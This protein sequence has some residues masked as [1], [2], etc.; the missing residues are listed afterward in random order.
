MIQEENLVS[1]EMALYEKI[2]RL[3]GIRLSSHLTSPHVLPIISW[4]IPKNSIVHYRPVRKD[5]FGPNATNYLFKGWDRSRKV[6]VYHVPKLTSLI[7]DPRIKPFQTLLAIRA[8]RKINPTLKWIREEKYIQ[9]MYKDPNALLCFNYG[10]ADKTVHYRTLPLSPLYEW[11]NQ[12][13]TMWDEVAKHALL[14]DRQQFIEFEVPMNL[15]L[16]SRLETASKEF[17]RMYLEDFNKPELFDLL[18]LWKWMNPETRKQSHISIVKEQHLQKVNLLFTI[19]SHVCLLN[20]GK[21]NTWIM[22]QD[23]EDIDQ[24]DENEDGEA[25]TVDNTYATLQR[26]LLKFFGIMN[27]MRDPKQ[28]VTVV[29]ATDEEGKSVQYYIDNNVDV[30]DVDEDELGQTVDGVIATD[31]EQESKIIDIPDV[32]LIKESP[33]TKQIT[34]GK[35]PSRIKREIALK[36]QD[37]ISHLEGRFQE[38]GVAIDKGVPGKKVTVDVQVVAKPLP[39]VKGKEE[40][41]LA[42]F[43]ELMDSPTMNHVFTRGI[44]DNVHK[45][46]FNEVK[47]NGLTSQEGK[48]FD[49]T[50]LKFTQIKDPRNPN[51]TLADVLT[52][53]IPEAHDN[54]EEEFVDI[55]FVTD[56]SMLKTT[57]NNYHKKYI[58]KVLP[59]DITRSIMSLQKTGLLIHNYNIESKV[60]VAN[61]F[62]LH[63]LQVQPIGGA[64]STVH[65]KLPKIREDG[66]YKVG[67]NL[68]RLR[69]QRFDKPIRKVGLDKVALA[70]YFGKRF[71][72]R[73]TKQ[74]FNLPRWFNTQIQL[75][76]LNEEYTELAYGNNNYPKFNLGRELILLAQRFNQLHLKSKNITLQ[77]NKIEPISNKEG[78]TAF[79][80]GEGVVYDRENNTVIYDNKEEGI[81]EFLGLDT[82]TEP[83][84]FCEIGLLGEQIPVGLI[85][86]YH[87]GLSG[88]CKLLGTEYQKHPAGRVQ[89]EPHQYSLRFEDE[90][91][92]FDKNDKISSL[93]I[94]GLIP[95]T[96]SFRQ[97]S[98]LAFDTKDVYISV[99]S[100]HEL[101]IRFV[102]EFDL[103]SDMFVDDISRQILEKMGEPT[104]FELLLVRACE[105]LLTGY[106]PDEINMDDMLIKGYER[107]AGHVYRELVKA[108][109]AYKM[110]PITTKRRF[111]INPNEI[112]L[113]IQKDTSV[114]LVDSINP[115]HT[116]KEKTNVTFSG[117][118]GRS[119]RSMTKP[120][121]SYHETDLGTISEASTD[122]SD[123][124][125]TTFMS[126]NPKFTSL[127]GETERM[128]E[129]NFSA[130]SLFSVPAL[131]SPFAEFD[132]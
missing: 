99:M 131:L 6:W 8:Y 64:I 18:D 108:T 14:S 7:G 129:D 89:L 20:L 96:K 77:L 102:H 5:D 25:L 86:A 1:M 10:F 116:M 98:A 121:R 60:D 103:L 69:S 15:P 50:A 11:Q 104:Q 94:G 24:S 30:G 91:W 13:K 84:E 75:K 9:R 41:I 115:I 49:K 38:L 44:V 83:L 93:I 73:S 125:V 117:T 42:E 35:L 70:T 100:D 119:K 111:E 21:L 122:N 114:D 118:G 112:W 85:L 46:V 54:P 74:K 79:V 26:R 61:E 105:L 101:G 80:I 33:L 92:V 81:I 124:G 67:N 97:Y 90:V 55:P 76:I 72:T 59:R 82:S 53:E 12:H 2:Y 71:I 132:D 62:E 19:G 23:I 29:T 31:K 36:S 63:S 56:K 3:G 45:K 130:T 16:R 107:I 17:K 87:Y 52:E 110:K 106:Q 48:Y 123:V 78:I 32:A 58:T 120:T 40:E 47:I 39:D 37:A 4:E 109:R 88:L 127:Y 22:G 27:N 34:Q 68:Y 51:R 28:T 57:I 65:V 128:N 113:A 66:T 43:K 126:A 95:F